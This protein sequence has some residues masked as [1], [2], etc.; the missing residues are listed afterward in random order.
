[1]LH[2]LYDQFALL[3]VTFQAGFYMMPQEGFKQALEAWS[4]HKASDG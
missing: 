1:M 3:V 2:A 4:F